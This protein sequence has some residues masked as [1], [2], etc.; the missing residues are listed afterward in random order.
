QTVL[1]ESEVDDLIYPLDAKWITRALDNL[2]VNASLH[3]PDGTTISV[4]VR[5]LRKDGFRY[6]GVCIEIRDNG[7]GMDEET[8]AHLFDRY[9]RGTNTSEKQVRGSGLGTAIA[10]QLI[11]AH[12]GHISVDSA[13]GR[14]TSIVVELPPQN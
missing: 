12:G 13:L 3:N 7:T 2:L 10:K 6:P 8:V 14:G 5:P 1:F 9:Y 4:E 11:E